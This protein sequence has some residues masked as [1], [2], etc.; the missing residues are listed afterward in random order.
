[1]LL[2]QYMFGG[3]LFN[4]YIGNWDVSSVTNMQDMFR[5]SFNQDISDWDVSNATNLSG[6]MNGKLSA[7]Y[8]AAYL[9]AI[10]NKWSLLS[11]N[12][13]LTPNFGSIK[14]TSAG[15]AG[16]AVLTSAPNNWTITDGGLV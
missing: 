16:K 5:V 11:V 8:N 4:Q 15:V 14:Y 1:M 13:N 2:M 12:P 7:N 3:S 9:D 6:F 10:Y